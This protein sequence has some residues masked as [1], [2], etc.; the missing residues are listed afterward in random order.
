M[1]GDLHLEKQNV[2]SYLVKS[3]HSNRGIGLIEVLVAAGLLAIVSVGIATII[4]NS[5]IEQKRVQIRGA[6]SDIKNRYNQL[7]IDN[8][9]WTATIGDTSNTT[10]CITNAPTYCTV[11]TPQEL[12]LFY[13]TNGGAVV[14][15]PAAGMNGFTEAGSECSGFVA[16]SGSVSEGNDAC[17]I[18]VSLVWQPLTLGQPNTMVRVTMRIVYHGSVRNKFQNSVETSYKNSSTPYPLFDTALPMGKYDLQIIRNSTSV[19]RQFTLKQI[20][21]TTF[22]DGPASKAYGGGVCPIGSSGVG[23]NRVINNVDADP[24]GLVALNPSGTFYFRQPGLYKCS[25]SAS[26]FGADSFVAFLNKNGVSIG[27]A[28]G[29]AGKWSQVSVNFETT[30]TVLKADV[31]AAVPYSL[32]QRCQSDPRDNVLTPA[33]V[34][35]YGMGMPIQTYGQE[36]RFATIACVKM[37]D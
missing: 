3:I 26:S 16:P 24:T 14:S 13:P 9:S 25:V 5:Q 10:S 15:Y 28:S 32:S 17:P 18:G 12:R 29:Y 35:T 37:D 4:V 8:K 21:D 22:P 30:I 33:E 27:S 34:S 7:I 23:N 1:L 19:G 20:N 6:I 11:G 2:S 36:T 31:D